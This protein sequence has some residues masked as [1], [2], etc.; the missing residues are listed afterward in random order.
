ML[1]NIDAFSSDK[2]ESG[3]WLSMEGTESEFLIASTGNDNF[4]RIWAKVQRPFSKKIKNDNLDPKISSGLMAEALSQAVLLDWK[5]VADGSGKAVKYT[6]EL[7][8]AALLSNDELREWVV[9]QASQNDNFLA[10][11]DASSEKS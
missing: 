11:V 7:G 8:K 6:Q 9:D 4:Q 2:K 3:T 10:E 5:N 1:F